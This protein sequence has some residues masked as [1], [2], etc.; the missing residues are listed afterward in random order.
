V[1]SS[2]DSLFLDLSTD[3]TLATSTGAKAALDAINS[4]ISMTQTAYRSLYWDDAKAAIVNGPTGSGS[5][6][7]QKQLA[8]YQAALTRLSTGTSSV[9]A[10]L[11]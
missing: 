8:N 11:L 2:G 10:A 9:S 7:Q 1:L 5:A 4:A 3:L 6:E